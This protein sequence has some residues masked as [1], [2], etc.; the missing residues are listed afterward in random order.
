MVLANQNLQGLKYENIHVY[1]SAQSRDEY[2]NISNNRKDEYEHVSDDDS[3][4]EYEQ[5]VCDNIK[6]PKIS[7]AMALLTEVGGRVLI[8]FITLKE[9]LRRYLI[10][11]KEAINK[12][13]G[14]TVTQ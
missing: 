6:P 8:E 11:F 5:H 3:L 7:A 2:E 14:Y 4:Q 13:L 10:A 9:T 12:W 1:N